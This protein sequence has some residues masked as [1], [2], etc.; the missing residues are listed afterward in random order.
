MAAV[1]FPNGTVVCALALS[2]RREHDP[3]RHF[4][5]YFDPAW[6]P[7]WHA[8]IVD[9]VDF[10]LPT[11]FERAADQICEAFRRAQ[12]GERVEIGCIGGLG[13]TGTALACMAVLAGIP[14]EQAV[15]WVRQHYHQSAI[16][17][18]HQEQWVEWFAEYVGKEVG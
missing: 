18:R 9:W 2:E 12:L 15:P 1:V 11:D 8:E 7:S 4:G 16:N 10:G 6:R 5:L 13:R 17:N 3:S 14:A